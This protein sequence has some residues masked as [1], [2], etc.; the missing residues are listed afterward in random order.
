MLPCLC[1]HRDFQSTT[2][3]KAGQQIYTD[4]PGKVAALK[5][6]TAWWE[7]DDTHIEI[8]RRYSKM[9]SC[10]S[11]EVKLRARGDCYIKGSCHLEKVFT[12]NILKINR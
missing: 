1:S 3:C 5:K 4:D 11:K 2:L 12:L 8:N 9:W 7:E 6:F 10:G